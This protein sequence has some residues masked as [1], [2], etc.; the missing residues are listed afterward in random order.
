MKNQ[1]KKIADK[2]FP[3][4]TIGYRRYRDWARI[5]N[6][7][8]L[9]KY[10][11]KLAGN[12]AMQDG[13]FEPNETEVV[14]SLLESSDLFV[15]IGANI[16]YYCCLALSHDV[17][18]VAFEPMQNNLQ[19]LQNNISVNN[20][21]AECEIFPIALGNSRNSIKIFGD[22]TG[23]SVITGWSGSHASY[24]TYVP[25]NTLD[26]LLHSRAIKKTLIL[27]DIEGGEY[28]ALKGAVKLI[29]SDA[30]IIWL[31]EI[32]I[33]EHQPSGAKINPNLF[34]TF[35]IL[36]NA[37]YKSYTA[38]KYRSEINRDLINEIVKMQ[39]NTLNTHNF[40]FMK[41]YS[42]II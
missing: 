4:L 13:T 14:L 33:D 21:K 39:K 32:C 16:G 12:D 2:F 5:K 26:T 34:A 30:N 41:N 27:M 6:K 19:L 23:A 29:N 24:F 42:S 38:D 20:F 22:G 8:K 17:D 15:N 9:T 37:G 11:F 40:I 3:Q 1:L 7:P 25:C 10:G 31:I 28:E 35:E 36:W 18:T